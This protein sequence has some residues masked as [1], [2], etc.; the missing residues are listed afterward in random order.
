MRNLTKAVPRRL[1]TTNM[2][3]LYQLTAAILCVIIVGCSSAPT[4]HLNR[5]YLN[6]NLAL[7]IQAK[8]EKQG[9]NV[10]INQHE[11][12]ADITSTSIVYSPFVRDEQIVDTVKEALRELNINVDNVNSLF[13]S[14]HWYTQNTL[15]LF[16]VPQGV[17]VNS[18]KNVADLAKRYESSLCETDIAIDLM[19]NGTFKSFEKGNQKL[20]GAWSI[21]SY[22]YILLE[23]KPTYFNYYFEV[24]VTEATDRIGKVHITS[25][26]PLSNNPS[27]KK[28]KVN[29]GVR[30]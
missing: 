30:A 8:L 25:L 9:F 11:Y 7:S 15:G 5:L 16:I 12:P 4:V 19:P 24:E 18:G 22:P 26:K 10:E 27:I 3:K 20:K 28:C 13:S 2:M 29:Y 21:T 17:T 1:T 6:E 23:N 14:N